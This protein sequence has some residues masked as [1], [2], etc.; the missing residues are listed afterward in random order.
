[1]VVIYLRLYLNLALSCYF[2]VDNLP[3]G[4][5]LH[6]GSRAADGAMPAEAYDDIDDIDVCKIASAGLLSLLEN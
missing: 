5:K 3:H 1:M 4:A 2:M 6:V